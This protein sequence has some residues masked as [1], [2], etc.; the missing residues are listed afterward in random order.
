MGPTTETGIR[1]APGHPLLMLRINSP[2][3]YREL[4]ELWG[5]TARDRM[6]PT[7]GMQEVEQRRSSCREEP[8]LIRKIL[9]HVQQLDDPG[10]SQARAPPVLAENGPNRV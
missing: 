1:H 4:P 5:N 3:R 2:C 10:C 9:G 7:A 6:H 8:A